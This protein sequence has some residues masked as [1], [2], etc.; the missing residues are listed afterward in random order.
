[1]GFA[2]DYEEKLDTKRIQNGSFGNSSP[3]RSLFHYSVQ[4]MYRNVS[5]LCAE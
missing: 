4:Q 5:F 1:M 3:S 2:E